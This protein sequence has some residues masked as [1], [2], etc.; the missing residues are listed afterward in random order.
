MAMIQYFSQNVTF[1]TSIT[2]IP[3]YLKQ[4]WGGKAE[5]LAARLASDDGDRVAATDWLSRAESR[6]EHIAPGAVAAGGERAQR[7]AVIA[8]PPRDDLSLALLA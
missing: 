4:T 7:V 1:F 5:L 8:L 3:L 6:L 2:W